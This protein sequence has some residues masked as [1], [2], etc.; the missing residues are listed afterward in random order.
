MSYTTFNYSD[1]SIQAIEEDGDDSA[2][3]ASVLAW[4]NGEATPIAEGSSRAFWYVLV[5]FDDLESLRIIPMIRLHRPAYTVSFNV[6][7]SG[8]VYGGEVRCWQLLS[9]ILNLIIIST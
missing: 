1:L 8:P 4:K 9:W 3:A 5:D 2:D 6:E 7:N